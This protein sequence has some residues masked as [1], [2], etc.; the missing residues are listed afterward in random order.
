MRPVPILNTAW[1]TEKIEVNRLSQGRKEAAKARFH[2][3]PSAYDTN[4]L[5]LKYIPLWTFIRCLL[6]GRGCKQAKKIRVENNLAHRQ[7]LEK[8]SR[9]EKAKERKCTPE[10]KVLQSSM[11]KIPHKYIYCLQ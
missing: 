7:S 3:K 8:A 4:V 2:D 6:D 1:L 11:Q 10:K 9:E 5:P